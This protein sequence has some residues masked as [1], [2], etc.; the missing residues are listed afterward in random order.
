MSQENITPGVL[1]RNEVS[2]EEDMG[3]ATRDENSEAAQCFGPIEEQHVKKDTAENATD[4]IVEKEK[5]YQIIGMRIP[6]D[7]RTRMLN[8]PKKG[9]LE[10]ITEKQIYYQ[11]K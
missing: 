5:R 10:W 3:H 7:I 8:W 1:Q 4:L 2:D 9:S 11:N 6:D